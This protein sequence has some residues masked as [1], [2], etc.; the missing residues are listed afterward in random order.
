MFFHHVGDLFNSL[1]LLLNMKK[2]L[3]DRNICIYLL[4]FL[5]NVYILC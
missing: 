3:D 5:S 1:V 4:V 2:A